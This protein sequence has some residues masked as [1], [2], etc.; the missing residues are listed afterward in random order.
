MRSSRADPTEL[1]YFR[2][3]SINSPLDQAVNIFRP[4]LEFHFLQDIQWEGVLVS[5]TGTLP[6]NGLWRYSLS[7]T[8]ECAQSQICTIFEGIRILDPLYIFNCT[9]KPNNIRNI[10]SVYW[11]GAPGR[12]SSTDK[13]RNEQYHFDFRQWRNTDNV[14]CNAH[15]NRCTWNQRQS[16]SVAAPATTHRTRHWLSQISQTG[17]THGIS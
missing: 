2:I 12:M 10:G 16:Q 4:T 1:G 17:P 5:I 6:W 7:F 8:C 11:R 15:V 13:K 9:L 3:R 14:H